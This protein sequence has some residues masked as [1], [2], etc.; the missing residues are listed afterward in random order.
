MSSVLGAAPLLAL[1]ML[2]GPAGCNEPAAD[3]E[4]SSTGPSEPHATL[5]AQVPNTV[6]DDPKVVSVQVTAR[7]IGCE[8]PAPAPCTKPADPPLLTGDSATCP[9]SDPTRAL[10]VEVDFAAEF[11]VEVVADR[12]P[13]AATAECYAA[14]VMARS[15]LVTGIDLDVRATKEL[16]AVGQPCPEG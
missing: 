11:E 9:I 14:S 4:S 8:R 16:V 2:A 3:G 10:G 7:Q 6:C 15:V 5:L 13:E 1:A 12:S